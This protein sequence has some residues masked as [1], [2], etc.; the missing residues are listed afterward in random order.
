[1]KNIKLNKKSITI[2]L[3]CL[4]VVIA[5]IVICILFFNKNNQEKILTNKLG[6]MGTE[7]YEEFYYNQIGSNDEERSNFLKKFES[8]GIKV[9][10][11]NLSRYS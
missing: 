5:A 2:I 9:N 8:T 10:L 4:I 11:D 7:F 6:E 3:S 1:M